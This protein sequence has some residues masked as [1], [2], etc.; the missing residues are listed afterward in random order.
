MQVGCKLQ[1]SYSQVTRRGRGDYRGAGE[2]YRVDRSARTY[3]TENPCSR[4]S[5]SRII[6]CIRVINL[7]IS[8]TQLY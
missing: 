2:V 1:S 5:R 7:N 3:H 6:D 8:K 4:N